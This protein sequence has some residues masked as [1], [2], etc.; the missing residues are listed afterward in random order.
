MTET[1]RTAR[2]RFATSVATAALLFGAGQPASAAPIAVTFEPPVIEASPVCVPRADKAEVVRRWQ[3]WD[4]RTLPFNGDTNAIRDDLRFLVQASGAEA[5]DTVWRAIDVLHAT[6]PDYIETDV[7]L[8]KADHLIDLGLLDRL[9]EEKLID[10]ILAGPAATSARAQQVAGFAL[11][12]GTGI[13]KDE[14][15][16]LELL[17]SSAYSGNANALLELARRGS[18]GEVIAGWN[19]E[20]TLAITLAFGALVG[21]IDPQICERINRIAN[22]YRLGDLVQQ[23]TALAERWFRLSADLGDAP[24]A[25]QVAQFHL[26][27]EGMEK[28]NDVLLRYLTQAA[29]AGLGYAA[30]SL[31]RMYDRGGIVERE[32]LLSRAYLTKAAALGDR[33]GLIWLAALDEKESDGSPATL[34]RLRKSLEAVANLGN[35]P[36]VAL[37]KLARI[38]M[39]TEGRWAAEAKVRAL[40]ARALE[41]ESANEDAALL[42]AELDMRSM[43]TRQDFLEIV[44]RLESLVADGGSTDAMTRLQAAFLCQSPDAPEAERYAYWREVEA[45]A[46]NATVE[47]TDAEIEQ[48]V[49]NPD[50]LVVAEIQG[51]ALYGREESVALYLELQERAIEAGTI[52]QF[53]AIPE[54]DLVRAGDEAVVTRM[55]LQTRSEPVVDAISILREATARGD[56]TAR[57][58][59]ARALLSVPEIDGPMIAEARSLL[60]P[61]AAA[62]LGLA[63]KML[64]SVRALEG[65]DPATIWP[66]YR[67]AIEQRG[68][69]HALVYALP[70]LNDHALIDEYLIRARA[71]VDC[72]APGILSLADTLAQ[73]GRMDDALRWLSIAEVASEGIDWIA[74]DIADSYRQIATPEAD[75]KAMALLKR[76]STNG[77]RDAVRRL[78]EIAEADD[79]APK[80]AAAQAALYVDLIGSTNADSVALVLR[81]LR[82]A[83][84]EVR[85][86][87]AGQIDI[88][89]LY[90]VAADAG[91]A[92]AQYEHAMNLRSRADSAET[93]EQSTRYLTLAAE[94]GHARAMLELSEAYAVGLGTA[95]SIDASRQWLRR[96][97]A[98]GSKEAIEL[99]RL[100]DVTEGNDQ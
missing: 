95:P 88:A 36:A 59:L 67:E 32:P 1:F 31:G 73:M 100:A 60:E 24:A 54:T 43:R 89:E 84:P 75:E 96:A 30:A 97:A 78:L 44:A 51:Q 76:A 41:V 82:T 5:L 86:L 28:D 17:V 47:M 68:D 49:K 7:L 33:N 35:P 79:A 77:R 81:K 6:N 3:E 46:A 16:G 39:Q 50:P 93:L 22:R 80:T 19:I 26:L 48:F 64:E 27:A 63:I 69:F 87:V 11:L 25:W 34:E 8:D 65:G 90:A 55:R 62:G 29:D 20:P 23:D 2:S 52:S 83:D 72:R 10:A 45:V 99:V 4:G 38:H 94:Q 70:K 13:A 66:E 91:D 12:N 85:E 92:V 37:V 42:R 74:V 58:E 18:E 15:R 40:M 56:Q 57:M 21:E 53:P 71:V 98:A 9:S 61:A 14:K